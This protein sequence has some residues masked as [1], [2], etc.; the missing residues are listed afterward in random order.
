MKSNMMFLLGG[1]CSV[2]AVDFRAQARP[3]KIGRHGGRPS[4]FVTSAARKRLVPD[5]DAAQMA[6]F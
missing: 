2:S 3:A 1:R 6:L 4:S 5:P